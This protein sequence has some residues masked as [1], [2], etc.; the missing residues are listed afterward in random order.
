[1]GVD[2]MIR[3]K[4]AKSL[5]GIAFSVVMIAPAAPSPAMGC[6][7]PGTPNNEAVT[8]NASKTLTYSF[9]NTARVSPN[10][11]EY[12]KLPVYF[13]INMKEAGTPDNQEWTYIENDGP[14][15][16]GYK[17]KMTYTIKLEET[18]H[19]NPAN[20]RQQHV[21]RPLQANKTYCLRVWSRVAGGM[22]VQRVLVLALRQSQALEECVRL[23]PAPADG[24]DTR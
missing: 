18:R 12:L 19:I 7:T 11:T 14:H 24:S 22:P 21:D 2:T 3:S 1:V 16:L 15:P 5:L 20:L 23:L 6:D 9:D 17:E 10:P 13:D 8:S 4:I